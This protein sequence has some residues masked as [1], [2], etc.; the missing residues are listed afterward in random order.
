VTN[1]AHDRIARIK[2]RLIADLDPEPKWMRWASY[3]WQVARFDRYEAVFD[4][5]CAALVAKL[6]AR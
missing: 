4:Y 6:T 1:R 2:S 3:D 5:G